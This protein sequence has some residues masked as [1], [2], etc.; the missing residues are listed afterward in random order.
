MGRFLKSASVLA[1]SQG[2]VAAS[3][4]LRN[5]VIARH[6]SVADFGVATTFALTMSL[7]EMT[8]TLALDRVL[9]QDDDGASDAMLASALSF[10]KGLITG[11]I[12]FGIAG[13]VAHVF[14]LPEVTWAFRLLG[15]VPVIR[16][17]VHW[18]MVVRQRKMD[19][20]ATAIVDAVPQL[21]SVLVAYLAARS[22]GDYRVML[23]VVLAQV[24][25]TTL[26]SHVLATRPYRWLLRRDLAKKKLDFG[27]PLLVNGLLMFG[28]FQGD[29]VVVGA[30][31]DMHT[32]GWY[33]VAFSLAL[34]TLILYPTKKVG[35][36]AIVAAGAVVVEDVPPYAIV[37]GYP[38]QVVRYRF[39][40]EAIERLLELRWWDKPF[41]ELHRVRDAFM[42]PLEGDR[43]R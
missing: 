31:F 28:I 4:F 12:L 23:V 17:L 36:G 37:A 3:S 16:G 9:V 11:G 32:L 22:L 15:L 2:L 5:V 18:D 14:E 38:A 25:G 26:L 21:A 10:C 39:S 29:R 6:I 35:H 34:P 20:K 19:F 33:S 24:L 30:L 27:W 7:V 42:K 1:V 13:P 8:S 41:E 40:R 43:I